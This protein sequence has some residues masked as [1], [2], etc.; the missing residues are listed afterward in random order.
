MKTSRSY[1]VRVAL[2]AIAG[3]LAALASSALAQPSAFVPVQAV[4]PASAAAV[5]DAEAMSTPL[6]PIDRPAA[7][8]ARTRAPDAAHPAV[9]RREVTAR[10]AAIGA[11]PAPARATCCEPARTPQ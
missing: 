4:A 5:A 2:A 10:D 7:P 8:Q 11:L 1:T 6:G 3:L 9:V